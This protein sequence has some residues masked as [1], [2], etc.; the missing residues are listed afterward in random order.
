MNSISDDTIFARKLHDELPAN[1]RYADWTEDGLKIERL[2]FLSDPGYP[3]ADVSYCYGRD[4]DGILVRVI[5]PFRELPKKNLRA[6]LY[7]EAKKSGKFIK[8]LFDVLS[9]F[10]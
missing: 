3:Y 7:N 1:A 10:Q 4:R 2:R 8:G 9:V 5:L 6:H